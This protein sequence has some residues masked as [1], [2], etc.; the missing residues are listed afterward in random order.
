[1]RT[2]PRYRIFDLRLNG[3]N[4]EA[5]KEELFWEQRARVNW[6]QHGDRNTNFFHKMA[7][8]HYFRGRISELEDEFGNHTTESVNM[9][10]IASTYFDKLFS[11]SA[12][13]SE[14]HLFDLVK[15]KITASMNEA[16][17]KQFTEDEICQA[18]K[19]MPP[20]KAPGVDGFAAIFYQT[21]WHIVGTDISKYY[22]AILNGQ[23]E[24]ED[25]NRT[26][27]M[28]I[29][30][31]DKPNNMS[32]FRPISLCN[33]L[34]KIIA[35]VLVNRMS[36]MLGDCINEPQGA[37][38][39]GRLISDNILIAYEILHSLK[40]KKRGKK[41]NFALKLD[42]SKAYDRVEWDFLAGMMNSLGFH[43]DWIVLIMRCVC[44]VSYSVSLNGLDS[45]WFSPSRGLRQ[46]DLLSPYLFLICAKG[47]ATLLEDVK[48][49]MIMEGAPIGRDRLSINHLFFADDCILF[50]DTSLEG[51]RT[52]HKVINEYE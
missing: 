50:G 24:F 48:Q 15:R 9:L 30:K 8:Q 41:G 10:K 37:F 23:L 28:L 26:R 33:V 45:D 36:D 1:M 42:M 46:G 51:T 21:Y 31:V 18:V 20:L 11:A 40:M 6:L 17:L 27:I 52:V 39:P 38:I 7:G 22:L 43:N 29:P 19:E 25:I 13:E 16:L 35:K 3:L 44:S 5:D 4:L 34:Y 2:G 47:F 14:E 49:R 32:Q 12:E